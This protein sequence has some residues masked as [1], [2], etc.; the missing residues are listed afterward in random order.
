VEKEE[1]KNKI[2]ENNNMSFF[3]NLKKERDVKRIVKPLR[4]V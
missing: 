4:K 3:G 1:E 2:L